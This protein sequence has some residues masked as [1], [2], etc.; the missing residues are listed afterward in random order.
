MSSDN[1]S[2]FATTSS[3]PVSVVIITVGFPSPVDECSGVWEPD[4]LSGVGDNGDS[5]GRSITSP[6]QMQL[7]E[8]VAAVSPQAAQTD[9]TVHPYTGA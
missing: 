6:D 1:F 9:N 3:F 7:L 5:P 4:T 2:N 8:T